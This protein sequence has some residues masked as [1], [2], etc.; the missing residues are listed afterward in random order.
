MIKTKWNS[1]VSSKL[2]M[3]VSMR[4]LFNNSS[5]HFCLSTRLYYELAVIAMWCTFLYFMPMSLMTFLISFSDTWKSSP[6]LLTCLCLS[7]SVYTHLQESMNLSFSFIFKTMSST[8]S[9]FSVNLCY[10]A[11]ISDMNLGLRWALNTSTP[12]VLTETRNSFA[13][14]LYFFNFTNTECTMSNFSD[15]VRMARLLPLFLANMG[16]SAFVN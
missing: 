1:Y 14:S 8:I 7:N 3:T 10:F 16:T 6:R 13:T 2:Q 15:W 11:N 4:F 5:A 12:T 9:H